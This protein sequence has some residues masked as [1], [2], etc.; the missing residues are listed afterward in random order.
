MVLR[1][2]EDLVR[3]VVSVCQKQRKVIGRKLEYMRSSEESPPFFFL[4]FKTFSTTVD[5]RH[6]GSEVK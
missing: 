4:F 6:E 5:D 1:M 3:I 2:K